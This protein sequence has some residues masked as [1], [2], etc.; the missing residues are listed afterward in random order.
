M[1]KCLIIEATTPIICTRMRLGVFRS[2]GGVQSVL[3]V[4]LVF[5]LKCSDCILGFKVLCCAR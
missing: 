4:I 1:I 3:P 5:V 2:L